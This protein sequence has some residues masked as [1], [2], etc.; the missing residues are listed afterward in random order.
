LQEGFVVLAADCDD[1]EEEVVELA[2]K[3]EEAY[4]LPFVIV[5]DSEGNYLGGASGMQT[6]EGLRTLLGAED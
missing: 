2:K 6:P 5:A 4:M 3:I 1:P